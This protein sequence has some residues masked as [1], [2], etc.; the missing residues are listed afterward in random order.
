[1]FRSPSIAYARP[2]NVFE[3]A[4]YRSGVS[5]WYTLRPFALT[6]V[7]ATIFAIRVFI[8]A[9]TFAAPSRLPVTRPSWRICW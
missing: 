6:R 5:S 3:V 9:T 7:E 4:E 1:M 2:M 8:P